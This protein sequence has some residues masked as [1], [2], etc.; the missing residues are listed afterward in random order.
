M[1]SFLA[2]TAPAADEPGTPTAVEQALEWLTRTLER[3][4]DRPI[5]L[6]ELAA[7]AAVT[8]KHLCRLFAGSLGR[9]PM[10]TVRLMR[11]E[12][13]LLLLA[14]SN[15]TVREVAGLAGFASPYH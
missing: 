7:A 4:P 10:Q 13:S 8:P 12:R 2:P 9:S 14:R 6:A 11:L 5:S 15:L 1:D 3:E